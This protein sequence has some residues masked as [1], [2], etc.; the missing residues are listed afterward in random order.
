MIRRLRDR[1][2]PPGLTCVEVVALTT[3]YLEGALSPDAAARFESHIAACPN[4]TLYL[5]QL[6]TT[7][8]AAGRLRASDLEPDVC[9]DLMRAF[10]TWKRGGPGSD[11][12]PTTS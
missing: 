5:D 4:C 10:A 3:D 12:R 9:D 7:M 8:A 1:L 11:S 6:R 2:R